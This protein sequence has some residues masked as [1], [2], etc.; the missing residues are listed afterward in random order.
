VADGPRAGL[1]RGERDAVRLEKRYVRKDGSIVWASLSI[2]FERD[3]AGEPQ[4]AI[5]VF[6]DITARRGRSRVLG[7]RSLGVADPGAT[8]LALLLAEVG[9]ALG[10]SIDEV[11]AP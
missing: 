2:A 11:E 8:S 6:D 7:D 10:V 3:A 5:S 4:Y 9:D 1:L